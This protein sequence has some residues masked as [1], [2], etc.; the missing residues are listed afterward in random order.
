MNIQVGDTVPIELQ[1]A[2]G[3]TN[4]YPRALVYDQD[5]ILLETVDL[6]HDTQGNY[7]GLAYVMP[8]TAF[9]KVIYIVYSDAG[10]TTPNIKYERDLEVYYLTDW[11]NDALRVDTVAEMAQGA[12]PANATI[13]EMMNYL[14]RKLIN[15]T[16]STLVR[17]RIFSHD[18]VTELFKAVLSDNAGVFTKEKYESGT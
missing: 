12:P 3:A 6:S 16:R 2:D 9:V 10:H 8:N 7:S 14:Y 17:D 18:G 15:E 5:S 13:A 4:Q 11:V 1:I